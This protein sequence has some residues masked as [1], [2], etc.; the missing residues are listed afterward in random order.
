MK[1]KMKELGYWLEDKLKDLCGE[2][3]P[4]KRL[5]VILIVLLLATIAN[6]YFTF[7][8]VYDWGKESER[9]EQ[10]K[11]EHI[12]SLELKKNRIDDFIDSEPRIESLDSILYKSKMEEH[13]RRNKG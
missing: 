12:K 13:E 2:I 4:D 10:L 3:T 11:M 7:K 8:V 1:E 6:L 5:T 9:K